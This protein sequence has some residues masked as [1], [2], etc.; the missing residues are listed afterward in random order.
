MSNHVHL[1][2][3]PEYEDSLAKCMRETH[4]RYTSFINKRE[5]W[6]GHLW[7]GRFLSF[8]LNER[9][10]Y[11]AVRYVENN[12]VRAGLVE[13]AE[14]YAWSSASAL[15]NGVNNFLVSECYLLRMIN[16]WGSYLR[17]DSGENL[18][19]MFRKYSKSGRPL[20]DKWFVSEIERTLNRKIVKGISSLQ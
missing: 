6:V 2:A 19:E 20:G 7:Q 12:P 8:P 4:K 3:V 9:H 18:N 10:L 5:G 16:N 15:V 1:I 14:E 13:N 17:E 11:A